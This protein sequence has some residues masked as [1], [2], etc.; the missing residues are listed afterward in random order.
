LV[1]VTPNAWL[2]FFLIGESLKLYQPCCHQSITGF[3]GYY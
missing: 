2:G 1:L 3:F